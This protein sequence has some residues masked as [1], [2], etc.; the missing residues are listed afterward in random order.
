[1]GAAGWLSGTDRDD[2]QRLVDARGQEWLGHTAAIFAFGQL[3][4]LAGARDRYPLLLTT[5]KL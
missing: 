4:L 5:G 3:G 2:V 1:M